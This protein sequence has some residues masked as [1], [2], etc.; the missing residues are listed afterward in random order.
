MFFCHVIQQPEKEL[1][2]LLF[3][4]FQEFLEIAKNQFAIRMASLFSEKLPVGTLL[5]FALNEKVVAIMKNS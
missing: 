3:C 2:T 4:K 1:T 5:A